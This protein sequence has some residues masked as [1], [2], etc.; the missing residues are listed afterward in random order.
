MPRW[1]EELLGLAAAV[2]TSVGV[3]AMVAAS[4]RSE[5]MFRDGDSL[6]TTLVVQSVAAGQPQDW[7][8]STVLFLPE[9]AV[10]GM[11]TLFGL[12]VNGTLALAGIVNL[13][14]FYGALRVV[15]GS[16][17]RVRAPIA[18]ALLAFATFG[19][20]AVSETSPSRDALELASLL[21]LTTY[22]S[23]TVIGVVLAV[24]LARRA[25]D[26]RHRRNVG[27]GGSSRRY[28]A[29]DAAAADPRTTDPDASGAVPWTPVAVLGVV[30][31]ASVVTNPLF[32]AWATVPLGLVLVVTW[33]L[34]RSGTAL[35]LAGALI[36]GTATGFVGRMP[37]APLIANTGAGY[38]DPSRWAESLGY[39]GTLLAERWSAPWGA[40]SALVLLA[41]WAW[42]VAA[43]AVLARRGDLGAAVVTAYGWVLPLLVVVGAIALGT[44][45]A[46]YLQPAAFAPL[47]GLIVVPGLLSARTRVAA[48]TNP[49]RRSAVAVGFAG[50][51]AVVLLILA[52]AVGVPR[53]VTAVTAPDADL[54]CVVEW[55][56]RSGRTGA[57]QFWT[58]RLPKAHLADPRALVQVDHQLRGYAWLVNRDDFAVGEVSFLVLDA[59]SPAFDLPEGASVDDA[60]HV[61]CGR[62]TIAD[63]G[64]EALPLGPQRS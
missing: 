32:A 45:A 61:S 47:L 19:L 21:T 23:A 27:S 44:N 60:R 24:G 16:T 35:W 46:R 5:L 36:A 9:T 57:G 31:A 51:G 58:V 42:C 12:G 43:T 1:A 40:A 13:V 59:Q 11:L 38:A 53:I 64:D 10:L 25:L 54:D 55:V 18:G 8:M 50:A 17:A 37:L 3:V 6:V 56:E 26:R 15:A 20:I 2:A 63:F 14:A 22:Y 39:Y 7:A 62:Y 28:S 52:G 33:A 34:T 48:S 49:S 30:A 29:T 41:L 4:A